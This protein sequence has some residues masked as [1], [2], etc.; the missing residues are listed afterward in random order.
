MDEVEKINKMNK[1]DKYNIKN[2]SETIIDLTNNIKSMGIDNNVKQTKP[3]DIEIEESK[4]KNIVIGHIKDTELEEREIDL[5]L[6]L[7]F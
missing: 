5:K 7:L 2:N 3:H 4:Q 6:K 1:I